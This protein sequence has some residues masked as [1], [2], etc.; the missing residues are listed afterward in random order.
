MKKQKPTVDTALV[1]PEAMLQKAREA[2][3]SLTIYGENPYELVM[4]GDLPESDYLAFGVTIGRAMEFAG[5]RIGDWVNFGM[6]T[7]NYKDYTKMAGVTGL[8][9]DYLREVSSVSGRVLPALRGV[10]SLERAKLM[11]RRKNEGETVDKCFKRLGSKS[12]VQLKQMGKAGSSS[13]KKGAAPLSVAD[14]FAMCFMCAEALS[15]LD[16]TK[17]ALAHQ[18]EFGEGPSKGTLDAL[19]GEVVALRD[20]LSDLG[21]QEKAES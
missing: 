14:V 10:A 19:R 5:W 17:W 20:A 21:S 12:T 1:A 13:T 8:S 6:A 11:L 3:A 16:N 7:F 4:P 15:A 2:S 18:L 9:E